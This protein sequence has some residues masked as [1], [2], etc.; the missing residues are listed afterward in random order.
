MSVRVACTGCSRRFVVPETLLGKSVKCPKCA[1]PFVAQPATDMAPGRAGNGNFDETTSGGATGVKA[2]AK[3]KGGCLAIAI[4]SV[5]AVSCMGMCTVG[6][7]VA[8]LASGR[9]PGVALLLPVDWKPFNSSD[10][11]F[12]IL[13]P[14]GKAAKSKQSD[15]RVADQAVETQEFLAKGNA[16]GAIYSVHCFDLPDAP[17][18][19]EFFNGVKNKLTAGFPNGKIA[20]EEFLTMID[21][22]GREYTLDLPGNKVVVRRAY[23]VECRVFI[24]TAQTSEVVG[25]GEPQVLRFV[26]H[27]E[28]AAVEDETDARVARRRDRRP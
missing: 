8:W 26:H 23:V 20:G 18:P 17:K 28:H 6:G 3:R 4:L 27:H 24:I 14:D 19:E 12:T 1:T 15:A 13:M 10:Y 11:G 16:P 7:L 5:L 21:Q 9:G 2:G 22:P 25:R